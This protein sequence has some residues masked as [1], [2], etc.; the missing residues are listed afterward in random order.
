MNITTNDIMMLIARVIVLFIAFP[1]HECAHAIVANKLGDPTARNLGRID[2][3]P[4]AHMV[5]LPTIFMI[6]LASLLDIST[7]NYMIGNMILLMTSIFFFRAVPIDSR[8]FRNRKAGI[9]LTALAGPLS[10]VLL[11]FIFLLIWKILALVLPFNSVTLIV[12][13][14][15]SSLVSINLQL[16]AFNLLPIPPLDG[17]N[18]L[19]FFLS[20]RVIYQIS[21]YSNYI[22]VGLLVLLY[23]TPVLDTVISWIYKVL[24]FVIDTMTGFV[25]IIGR[26]LG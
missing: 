12:N 8:Y 20:D 3:N 21:R 11:A 16:A 18:I 22:L 24:F 13:L 2:L 10:N 26:F 1:V 6:L 5:P 9:A 15:L 14:L 17:Y 25:D 23:A 7:H 4:L 19:S